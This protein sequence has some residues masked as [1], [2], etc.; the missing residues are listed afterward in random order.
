MPRN[1]VSYQWDTMTSEQRQWGVD[2]LIGP[3]VASPSPLD[4]PDVAERKSAEA[5]ATAAAVRAYVGRAAA[6]GLEGA[7]SGVLGE[8]SRQLKGG[9]VMPA[10][11]KLIQAIL[12]GNH[13]L[14]VGTS[15]V[16]K[17]RMVEVLS[18]IMNV[19][20]V[21]YCAQPDTSDME[22]VGQVVY[23]QRDNRLE[24]ND[25][26]LLQTA[27]VALIDEL[28]RI[29]SSTAN[30][31]LGPTS[32]RTIDIPNI[33]PEGRMN[34]RKTIRLPSAWTLIAT[35]NPLDYG[36]TA[37]RNEA[38]W[39]RFGIGFDQPHPEAEARL[40]M[41]KTR[42]LVQKPV[43]NILPLPVT[44]NEVRA[45]LAHVAIPDSL[46]KLLLAAS[47]LVSPPSFRKR[48]GYTE[49]FVGELPNVAQ[50]RKK[51]KELE[52]LSEEN[53]KEGGNP[54]GEEL[55][56][57][58][59]TGHAL[60]AGR[61]KVNLNDMAFAVR[62]ALRFRLKALPGCD[63]AVPEILDRVVEIVFPDAAEN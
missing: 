33:T 52:Q 49:S 1:P 16:G 5:Q 56:D 31:L 54:R 42:A 51:I 23:N 15:G 39:D 27:I 55:M 28:P 19:P 20:M 2:D 37:T 58:C 40:E 9:K 13:L 24:W 25:G 32:S 22:L 60:L 11:K 18:H 12:T 21:T 45:A 41:L 6:P 43:F 14:V 30:L 35:G 53:L 8:A 26:F 47:F 44:L 36:G 62:S 63:E 38:V 34:G 3:Q 61:L 46:R 57:L 29:A 48:V 59:A 17:T 4:P 50:L 10:L 7:G